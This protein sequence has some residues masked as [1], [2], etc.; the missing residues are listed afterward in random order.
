VGDEARAVALAAIRRV[1]EHG[2]YSNL[3]IPAGLRRSDLDEQDRA[4]AAELAYGTLR[5]L[6]TL[7][8]MIATAASRPPGRI[9]P[10]ALAALRLGAYQLAFTRVPDHAAVSETVGLTSARERGF[11]NAVLRA[12]AS[13]RPR[14]PAGGGDEEMSVRTGLSPWAVAELRRMLGRQGGTTQDGDGVETAAAAIAERADLTLRANR[15]RRSVADLEQDLLAA[16]H[17]PR[18]GAIHPDALTLEGSGDPA[19]LPGYEQGWF[20]VQ[21]Q[22][23]AFVV[24]ALDPQPGDRVLDACA[25]PGGKLSHIACLVGADG[26]AIGADLHPGRAGLVAATAA[27]LHVAAGVLAQDART[28]ALRGG[29]DRVLVDAPCSGLGSARRR[30]ELLWRARRSELSGLARTQ[31]AIATTAADQVRPGGLLVYSVCTFPRAETD[32]ACD[33]LLA[34][35]PDLEPA[36]TQG[37]DGA[38]ERV[39]LW[40]HLH[41]CDGMF[42]AAF[43]RRASAGR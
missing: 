10:G 43:R 21:D 6:L 7:D 39:R 12:L 5:R 26:L 36:A 1:T 33:A 14:P 22:A 8:W 16:G 3:A 9:S 34:K 38:S 23:S 4:F 30:P 17:H 35:R 18:R 28:P 20:A 42:V 24:A 31:V 11:V 25:G 40:P 13:R 32:A 15:C 27:R 19:A 2:G 37:P 41:G 29:F